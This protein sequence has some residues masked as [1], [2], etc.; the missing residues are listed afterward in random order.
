M[1]VRSD[2]AVTAL[3]RRLFPQTRYKLPV[4]VRAFRRAKQRNP[5]SGC[6]LITRLDRVPRSLRRD[7]VVI[8]RSA[9]RTR[10]LSADACCCGLRILGPQTGPAINMMKLS[11]PWMCTREHPLL[12]QIEETSIRKQMFATHEKHRSTK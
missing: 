11:A 3:A 2:P 12:A 10:R 1:N 9:K 4:G 7:N 5:L 6:P 8:A